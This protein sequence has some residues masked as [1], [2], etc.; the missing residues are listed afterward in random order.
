MIVSA[1]KYL[2]RFT[3]LS[4]LAGS[5]T[6]IT[7]KLTR[8]PTNNRGAR[9]VKAIGPSQIK[10]EVNSSRQKLLSFKALVDTSGRQSEALLDGEKLKYC[11]FI[12]ILLCRIP[13]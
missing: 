1:V 10:Q 8:N 3:H 12:F 6:Q 9:D 5:E 2:T 13:T 4:L 7:I 11:M